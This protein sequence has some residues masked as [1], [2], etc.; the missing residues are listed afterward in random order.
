[1]NTSAAKSNKSSAGFTLVELCVVIIILGTVIATVATGYQSWQ[2]QVKVETNQERIASASDRIND[3]K[4]THGHFPQ[5]ASLTLPRGDAN[6]GYEGTS[7]PAAGTCTNGLCAQT[8]V[9]GR[10]V[11]IGAL[12]FRELNIH[13]EESYDVYGS[14]IIY[15]VTETATADGFKENQGALLVQNEQGKELFKTD[16]PGVFATFSPGKNRKGGF[17]MNG[18]AVAACSG[19]TADTA[20]CDFLTGATD[21]NFRSNSYSEASSNDYFDDIIAFNRIPE[22]SSTWR[23]GLLENTDEKTDDLIATGEGNIYV[24]AQRP[25]AAGDGKL[26]I[27]YDS[28]NPS[29]FDGNMNIRG[30]LKTDRLCDGADC[31]KLAALEKTCGSGEYVIGF[32]NGEPQCGPIYFGCKDGEYMTGIRA[33]GTAICQ[34]LDP[35]KF[36]GECGSASG[37]SL[38][39]PP[40]GGRLCKFGNSGA[41]TEGTNSWSWSCTQGG[42]TANCSAAKVPPPYNG[43]CGPANG[44]NYANAPAASDRCSMGTMTGFNASSGNWSWTCEGEGPGSS[45]ASCSANKTVTNSCECGPGNCVVTPPP[46]PTVTYSAVYPRRT[47]GAVGWAIYQACAVRDGHVGAGDI[48]TISF[49]APANQLYANLTTLCQ[50]QNGYC[51]QFVPSNFNQGRAFGNDSFYKFENTTSTAN[52]AGNVHISRATSFGTGAWQANNVTPDF[53][54][55]HAGKMSI[56]IQGSPDKRPLNGACGSGHN[57]TSPPAGNQCD[58][59]RPVGL[60]QSGS[61]YTWQC[62]GIDGGTTADCFTR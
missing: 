42:Q 49:S 38:T 24:G 36:P 43:A 27:L 1:M 50:Q 33:D 37:Q 4:K 45:N 30:A 21:A 3:Y 18:T 10:K 22:Q 11:L 16:F 29:V 51:C 58:A 15:T 55:E 61:R 26:S 31:M 57:G 39:D 5:P 23:R 7:F 53:H 52:V 47:N 12:P 28:T 6:Y 54:W 14:R 20:N 13:E 44:R 40:V 8:G 2:A 60:Q 34:V 56:S 48:Q 62:Q 19:T 25:I 9:S 32:Y 46:P 35:A 41:V 59:G 17:S